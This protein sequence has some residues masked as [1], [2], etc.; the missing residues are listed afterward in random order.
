MIKQ[1][2]KQIIDKKSQILKVSL[3]AVIVVLMFITAY[4]IEVS[5]IIPF[6]LLVVAVHIKNGTKDF[7]RLI[8]PFSLFAVIIIVSAQLLVKYSDAVPFLSYYFIPVIA[9]SMLTMVLFEDLRLTFIVTLLSSISA[10]KI[11]GDSI[12]LTIIFFIGGIMSGLLVRTTRRRSQIIKAGF[13]AGIIQSF[14]LLLI[15]PIKSYIL[16]NSVLLSEIVPII[17]SGIISSIIVLGSLPI[18]EYLFKIVTKISLLELSDFNHPLLKKMIIEA[19]G[20]YQHSLVVGNLAEA[21]SEAIGINS[22]LARVGAYYHDIGKIEKA[23]YFSENQMFTSSKH[24]KLQP[25]MSRLI[26][27]NHVKEGVE[28]SKKYKLNP[29]LEQFIAEHHGTSLMYYFYRRAL[30]GADVT[31]QVGEE[32]FRYP[33]PKPKRKEVAI[34]LLADS[35]EAACRALTEPTPERITEVVHKIINNKFIDGQ[36]DLCELTFNELNKIA[37]T[38]IYILSAVYHSR[39]QYPEEQYPQTKNED[40]YKNSSNKKSNHKSANKKSD[41]KSPSA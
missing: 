33:G 24:D 28:L 6:L 3:I 5:Y 21:A 20:T 39:V 19:P 8:L 40:L 35:V 18:F 23:E 30:E 34:V 32:G 22:L 13:L 38:F 1:I 12:N 25:S 37:S 36:L 27:L 29:I 2:I 4:L 7:K 17:T 41:K 14:C 11:A 26:I 10:G 9:I 15:Y 31:K 16:E